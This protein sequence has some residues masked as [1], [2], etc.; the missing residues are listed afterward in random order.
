MAER[1]T[2]HYFQWLRALGAVGIVVLHSV[3]SMSASGGYALTKGAAIATEVACVTLGRWAVPV[4]FMMSGALM[5][6]PERE[7]GWP[8]LLRHV[9]RLAFVL[10]TFGLGFCLIE[11]YVENGA[12]GI[13][14]L[15]E[16]LRRL[17]TQNSWDHLW[18][19]YEL[20]GFYL[21]TPLIRPWVAQATRTEYRRVTI[22]A[23]A[24]LLGLYL[25]SNLLPLDEGEYL[26]YGFEVP[27]C[28]AY[29]LLGSY[30]HRY[31]EL[32]ARFVVAGVASMLAAIVA[33]DLG[34][35][36]WATDPNTGF[37]APFA[38]LVMLLAKRY[39]ETPVEGHRMAAL[40]A[41]Y[42]F[43][44]YLIH[45]A[46]IHLCLMSE[47]IQRMGALAACGSMSLL[48]L[49]LSVATVWVLRLIPGVKG[50]V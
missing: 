46:F 16:A 18:F 21:V 7:M 19:V 30:V 25:L 44:I 26:Y 4:F 37:I 11:L 33:A 36:Y 2:I 43:G 9:W 32:D 15:P 6:D 13:A 5:L 8:K 42:S 22:A 27:H 50:K 40:L 24:L 17:A 45:P 49:V 35:S 31:L 23:C 20:L 34:Y 29:Y 12:L 3:I 10:L 47:P 41:D 28:F 38:V 14:D 48:S 39:L 1:K